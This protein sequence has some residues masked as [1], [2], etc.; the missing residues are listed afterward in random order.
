VNSVSIINPKNLGEVLRE[1]SYS[2]LFEL[3][4]LISAEPWAPGVFNDRK[5]L[6]KNLG[7]ISLLVLDVD[8]GC[9]LESAKEQFKD[10]RH[11][12]GTSRSHQKE[13]NGV[14]CDRFRV[15]LFLDSEITDDKDF[16]A[17]WETASKRW[18]FI[19]K[20]CKDSSRFFYPS[21]EIVS[22]NERGRD[23]P[24][25]V[26]KHLQTVQTPPYRDGSN[27]SNRNGETVKGDL[28]K[29]TLDLLT[30]GAPAGTRH[31]RLVSAVGNMREQGYSE[32]EVIELL[33]EMTHKSTAD[34]TQPGLNPADLKTI[35]R[36]F[37]R[38]LKY[39]YKPK[40]EEKKEPSVI[41]NAAELLPETFEYLADKDKVKGDPT[42]I[43]GLDRLL[44]GGFRTGELTVLMAQAKTGK[45][46]LYHY[47]I[48]KHL[49]RGLP[50]GYASR[51]L[52]PATEVIPNLAS[53]ALGKNAW[54]GDVTDEYKKLVSGVI[55]NWQ[56]YFAPGYGTFPAEDI[57]RWFRACTD[58][59]V[60]HFLFDHFHYALEG[61]DY[62]ATARL[63][64]RL[65]TLTKELDIHLS[66]I[67]Q[68]RSL[69]EGE[70]LS[71]ATL[72]GGAAIGQALDNLL[73]LERVRGETNISRL[74]LDQ[75]RHKLAS[76]G[77][78]YLL[79]DKETT[80]FQ[81]VE[82]QLVDLDAEN[83]NPHIPRGI[84][85]REGFKNW[86]RIS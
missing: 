13:K 27:V 40:E 55:A 41:V 85:G 70:A 21:P 59:G 14:V 83:K 42:G 16:K 74:K 60:R 58:L 61:E 65:K 9:D 23:Y 73:I 6:I 78:I 36:M 25:S 68:P 30:F 63:I 20:A 39:D 53:I 51:E 71:L 77:E 57:E 4:A 75:A 49:E 33:E 34:W 62:E 46:T 26:F 22:I 15:V 86:P 2:D 17:T 66:L 38:D 79:Y 11:I 50:F 19:D 47:L 37:K 5:R 82:R 31:T 32:P 84:Q 48:Y 10:Y 28:W 18:P 43:D 67:V 35:D 8:D 3:S 52:N 76:L 80:A 54:T 69:R 12:I 72:R 56:L 64:K 44:G 1:E 81:E 29:S 24:V 45:N 7:R